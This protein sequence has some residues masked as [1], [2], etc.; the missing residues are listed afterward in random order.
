MWLSAPKG[1]IDWGQASLT[2]TI[3]VAKH[4]KDKLDS[5]GD[6]QLLEDSV[7]VVPDGMFLHLK[8][9][10]DFAVLE[11]VGD[12]ADHIFHAAGPLIGMWLSAPKGTIDWGQASLTATIPVAKHI[13]DKLDSAGDPQLLE[14][15]VDVVP[16]GMFLHLKPL[17]DFAVLEAVGD[18]ADHIFHAAG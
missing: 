11:A 17:S 1:T 5:A 12:E 15:S 8:P 10:S 18:E 14:D 13:K 4:I 16:D 7:D 6:P 9:L 3:P 2:A